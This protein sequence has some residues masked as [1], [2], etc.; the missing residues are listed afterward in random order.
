[1]NY[2]RESER[3]RDQMASAPVKDGE[4]KEAEG[5]SE[6]ERARVE[7]TAG[8]S[9][10]SASSENELCERARGILHTSVRVSHFTS[11]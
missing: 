2:H 3:R 1:M 10:G 4:A 9:D 11:P 5:S 6:G 7:W 8:E